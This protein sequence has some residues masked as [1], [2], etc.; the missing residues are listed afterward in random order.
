MA[1]PEYKLW[2]LLHDAA[3]AYLGD[4]PRPIKRAIPD[5]TICE[6]GLLTAI[7]KKF[8]LPNSEIPKELLEI[9]TAMLALEANV[10]M[11]VDAKKEWHIDVPPAD[12][13]LTE[14]WSPA[15]AFE[16]FITEYV[17]LTSDVG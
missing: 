15:Q 6:A 11:D 12:Y 10:L 5:F 7:S 4:I 2:G 13:E 17:N 16:E 3:E 1:K 8:L 9:D 14:F